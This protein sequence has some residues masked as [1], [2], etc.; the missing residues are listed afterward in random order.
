M[1]RKPKITHIITGLDVGGAERSL[2]NLL[3][4]D[5]GKAASHSVISL[6]NEGTYGPKICEL[7]HETNC[8]HVSSKSPFNVVNLRRLIRQTNPDLIQGWMYHG[9]IATYFAQWLNTSE[10]KQAWNIRHCLYDIRDEKPVTQFAIRLGARQSQRA[11]AIIYNSQLAQ[12]QHE[13]F[14]YAQAKSQLIPNGFDT[15]LWGPNAKNR[16]R[17]RTELSLDDNNVAIGFVGRNHPVKDLPNFLEALKK[18]MSQNPEVHAVIVGRDCEI[19]RPDLAQHYAALNRNRI[20]ILGQRADVPEIMNGLDLFCL[21]SAAEAF[22]NV[23]GEAMASGLLCIST[24]V[25]DAAFVMADTGILVPP[26]APQALADGLL[27]ALSFSKSE[28]QNKGTSARARVERNFSLTST[29]DQYISLY[30]NLLGRK[31]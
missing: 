1:S 26:R 20:H 23:L 5:L 6:R 10:V 17:I 13:K 29:N 18:V 16:Q 24:N 31:L 30:G 15:S 11:D 19:T 7:G 21:S 25:G 2:Y 22:P 4:N 27:S 3:S 9:N 28:R 14:G 8:L 12:T